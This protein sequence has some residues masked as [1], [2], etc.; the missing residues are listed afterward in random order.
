MSP[1]HIT[2]F[3]HRRWT[4]DDG[5]IQLFFSHADAIASIRMD[6]GFLAKCWM[7]TTRPQP[8]TAVQTIDQPTN[9]RA[10]VIFDLMIDFL[11]ISIPSECSRM[12]AKVNELI[13]ADYRQYSLRCLDDGS[14]D[15]M[16]CMA[17][18][19]MCVNRTNAVARSKVYTMGL[20]T[21]D[22]D[23]MGMHLKRLP[24]CE[25]FTFCHA[26]S[27]TFHANVMLIVL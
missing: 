27:I 13:D 15:P 26:I 9:P 1:T 18:R 14:F 23:V 25:L 24:C 12:S 2:P 20:G 4:C 19:C 16:Q 7:A 11:V 22:G 5:I 10:N 3:A 17:D 8:W 21:G 6:N